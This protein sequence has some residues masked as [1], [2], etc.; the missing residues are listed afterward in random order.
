MVS[1]VEC[2]DFFLPW[3]FY[4]AHLQPIETPLVNKSSRYP[5][6]DIRFHAFISF[7]LQ[8]RGLGLGFSGL[9]ISTLRSFVQV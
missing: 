4:L 9:F 6:L 5:K 1:N 8:S 2:F 3:Y 7:S